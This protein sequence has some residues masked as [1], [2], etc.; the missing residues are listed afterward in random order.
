MQIFIHVFVW[1]ATIVFGRKNKQTNK[2]KQKQNK[3]KNNKNKNKKQKNKT[4]YI[5]MFF[6][7]CIIV[8][9]Q[10]LFYGGKFNLLDIICEQW[11]VV[12]IV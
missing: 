7:P 6:S 3:N 5:Y 2:Q 10:T 8:F 11:V 4:K 9:C 1:L 12:F